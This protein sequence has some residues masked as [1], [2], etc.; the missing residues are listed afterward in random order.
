MALAMQWR[1]Q[2][3]QKKH[4]H[5][6][7][8]HNNEFR[9]IFNTHTYGLIYEIFNFYL[10]ASIYVDFILMLLLLLWSSSRSHS[11][12]RYQAQERTHGIALN[13]TKRDGSFNLFTVALSLNKYTPP[14]KLVIAKSLP[15][16]LSDFCTH[17]FSPSL[18]SSAVGIICF[19]YIDTFECLN[20]MNYYAQLY[21]MPIQL[22]WLPF[23][24]T[25]NIQHQ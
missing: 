6:H 14:D 25:T 5:T 17:R 11:R 2:E 22:K 19:C 8:R 9:I 10:A 24:P 20:Y 23:K 12:G 13:E 16:F 7:T 21:I 3:R 15:F 1:W 4:T 18:R